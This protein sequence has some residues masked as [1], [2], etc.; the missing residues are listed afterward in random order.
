MQMKDSSL[1]PAR[2]SGGPVH[3][4]IPNHQQI[5]ALKHRKSFRLGLGQLL[6]R[7]VKLLQRTP[8]QVPPAGTAQRPILNLEAL[9]LRGKGD[10]E[11]GLVRGDAQLQVCQ[12]GQASQVQEG[13]V[14]VACEMQ[15]QMSCMRAA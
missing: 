12:L 10:A 1:A 4:V 13:H 14:G 7:A 3:C 5:Q 15:A 9:E 11:T 8:A 6:D 2:Q